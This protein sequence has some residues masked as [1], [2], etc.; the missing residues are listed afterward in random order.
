VSSRRHA[1]ESRPARSARV[2]VIDDDK[3]LGNAF[4]MTLSLEFEVR[5]VS[6]GAEA[7]EMLAEDASFD[8]IFCD[9]MMPEMSGMDVFAE[10]SRRNP[11]MT[12]KVFFMTGGVYSP[13]VRAFIAGVSNRC[14]QKPFDPVVVIR[15]ALARRK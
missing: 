14:L 5:V 3:V 2:L 11:E 6:S 15:D 9:L 4:R 8:F 13:E 12:E 7:L 1:A 10:I